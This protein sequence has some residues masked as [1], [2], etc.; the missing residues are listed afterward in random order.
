MKTTLINEQILSSRITKA[1]YLTLENKKGEEMDV[2]VENYTQDDEIMGWDNNQSIYNN[3]NDEIL[4]DEDM[5]KFMG[6]EYD[7][8]WQSIIT[9][10][11]I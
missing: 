9:D 3:E 11:I 10:E 5:E 2:R 1:Y 8:D 4:T 7:E 6:N